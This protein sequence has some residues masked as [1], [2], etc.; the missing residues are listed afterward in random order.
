[1]P[2][3]DFRNIETGEVWEEFCSFEQRLELLKDLNIEQV[4]CAPNFVSGIAGV[5]HKLDSGF[6]DMLSRVAAAN[7]HSPM[8]SI[9]GNKGIKESKTRDAVDREKARQAAR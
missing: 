2:F 3:Y 8:A 5:T 4:P 7:P 1:M 9:H 6:N